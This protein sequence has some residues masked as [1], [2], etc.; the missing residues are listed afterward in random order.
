[1]VKQLVHVGTQ[2]TRNLRDVLWRILSFNPPAAVTPQGSLQTAAAELQILQQPL[3]TRRLFKQLGNCATD[4][5]KLLSHHGKCHMH[6]KNLCGWGIGFSGS[7]YFLGIHDTKELQTLG[8][9]GRRST[10][11]F[12]VCFSA[13]HT[14]LNN[15]DQGIPKGYQEFRLVISPSIWACG[16]HPNYRMIISCYCLARANN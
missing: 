2:T 4:L 16:T 6:S 7:S 14:L 3:L 12:A 1:M 13:S 5:I 8:M 11:P 9:D 15:I 10:S